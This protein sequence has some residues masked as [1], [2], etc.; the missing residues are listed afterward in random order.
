VI[1]D[2]HHPQVRLSG[3][4]SAPEI[5]V[6]CGRIF[7]TM[8][9]SKRSFVDRLPFVTS[10][11]VLVRGPVAVNGWLSEPESRDLHYHGS[12]RAGAG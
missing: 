7:T 2:Y 8:A 11:G 10:M 3:G 6:H 9:L 1:G 4:G 5:T 12:L